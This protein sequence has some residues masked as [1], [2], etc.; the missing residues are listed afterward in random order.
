[1]KSAWNS[2]LTPEAQTFLHTHEH[3]SLDKLAFQK[4]K[5]P[6]IPF[7][8]V[9]EQLD[10]WRKIADKIAVWAGKPMLLLPSLAFQQASSAQTA[11]YKS[12]L[13]EGNHIA[14]LTGGLGV[15]TFFLAQ[16]ASE[17]WHIES[18]TDLHDIVRHNFQQ[19][20]QT[21]IFFKNQTAGSFLQECGKFDAFYIDP[22]RRGRQGQKLVLLADYE[23]DVLNLLP[24]MFE[25]TKNIWLKT[26]PLLDITQACEALGCV[27]A[28]YVIAHGQEVK[29]LLFHLTPTLPL[30][31]RKEVQI[32]AT[33]ILPTAIQIFS[34]LP[35]QESEAKPQYSEPLRYIYEP[36]PAILKAGAFKSF[37]VQYKLAKLHTHSHFYTSAERILDI[38][39]RVFE[40]KAVLPYKKEAI[41]K[42]LPA[43][44]AHVIARNFRDTV[45]QIRQKM[46]IAEGGESYLLATTLMAGE[47]VILLADRL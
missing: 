17:V 37:S 26:S 30:Q 42:A 15:D 9:L 21:N 2:L 7:P 41:K 34:F 43:M 11:A 18:N 6:N 20:G 40:L 33:T 5:F 4:A 19:L 45:A 12:S 38:P 25:K 14:D 47:Q 29:E 36:L 22:A 27:E 44:K 16:K 24:L 32:Y 8:E 28:V 1:M 39:A 10:S 13:I 23:P 3:I 35:T 31:F 46:Y